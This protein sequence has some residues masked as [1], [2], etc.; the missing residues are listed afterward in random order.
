MEAC[1]EVHTIDCL[2]MIPV[3]LAYI[4]ERI[5]IE[6]VIDKTSPNL[7]CVCKPFYGYSTH[8]ILLDNWRWCTE[9]LGTVE[10]KTANWGRIRLRMININRIMVPEPSC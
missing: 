10:L 4:D 1:K 6:K 8:C 9:E 7:G 5:S 2:N 3:E